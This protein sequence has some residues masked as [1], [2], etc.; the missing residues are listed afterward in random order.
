LISSEESLFKGLR[1]I[2]YGGR[3]VWPLIEGGVW[4]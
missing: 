4:V 3:E 1:P 2:R